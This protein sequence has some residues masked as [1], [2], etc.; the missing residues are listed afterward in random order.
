MPAA[1]KFPEFTA[2]LNMRFH[3]GPKEPNAF[4]SDIL[5]FEKDDHS[6]TVHAS[7]MTQMN[8]LDLQLK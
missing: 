1:A 7:V 3:L 5:N 4:S 6:M 8:L 2:M